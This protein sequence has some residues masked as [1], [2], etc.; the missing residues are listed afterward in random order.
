MTSATTV[1]AIHNLEETFSCHGLHITI[2]S[3]RDT[4]ENAIKFACQ[5]QCQLDDMTEKLTLQIGP[6]DDTVAKREPCMSSNL[7]LEKIKLPRFEGEI[8]AYPQF[9]LDLE[10][11]IMPHLQSDD[12]SYVLRSCLGSD[13]SAIV[14]SVDDDISEMWNRLDE[15]YGNPA[16][17]LVLVQE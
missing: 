16:K 10:K 12:V 17:G 8:R 7:Q 14:N 9:K 6:K 2:K 15:K 13:P 4:V 5:I 1:K 11:Q 3:D